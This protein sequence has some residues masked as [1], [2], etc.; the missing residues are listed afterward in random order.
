ME[1]AVL[2]KPSFV[3]AR[4]S[5]NA[6]LD[7]YA[8]LAQ[9]VGVEVPQLAVE[10]FMAV[11]EAKGLPIYSRTEVV[12]YMDGIAKRDGTGHGWEWRAIRKRD[13]K[14]LKDI[15][16]GT[17]SRTVWLDSKG[18]DIS[19]GRSLMFFVMDEMPESKRK[20]RVTPGSDYYNGEKLYDKTIPM[21]ALQRVAAIESDYKGP[22]SFVVSDYAT[23][24]HIKPDPFL[25]AILPNV[26]GDAGRFVVDFWD[27]PGFGIEQM[28]K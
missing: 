15:R 23:E 6:S 7:V 21:R 27:E 20:T 12:K 10:S 13:R 3:A 18:K 25:M 19:S 14:A 8:T 4:R 22:V 16:F 5:T 28:L 17:P 2:T 11:M 1:A 26:P 9:Q 24:P